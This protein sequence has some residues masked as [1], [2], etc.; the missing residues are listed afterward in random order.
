MDLYKGGLIPKTYQDFDLAMNGYVNGETE[1][2]T[3]INRLNS[4]IDFELLYWER[5]TERERAIARI[6]AVVGS[7]GD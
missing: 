1:A 2:L 6:E 5:F 3:V 7:A 4:L